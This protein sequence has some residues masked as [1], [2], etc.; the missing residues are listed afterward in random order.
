MRFACEI[1]VRTPPFS[2]PFAQPAYS[3]A[4]AVHRGRRGARIFPSTRTPARHARQAFGRAGAVLLKAFR[5]RKSA[6]KQ[7]PVPAA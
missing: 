7:S 1:V 6:P 4:Q 5:L 2:T 3:A